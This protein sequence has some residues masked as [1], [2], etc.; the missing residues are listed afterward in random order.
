MFK[1]ETKP[2]PTGNYQIAVQCGNGHTT[3]K[4]QMHPNGP[5][6]CGQPTGSGTC[7]KDVY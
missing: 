6:K 4:D 2:V 5:Y 7:G 3:F 1:T